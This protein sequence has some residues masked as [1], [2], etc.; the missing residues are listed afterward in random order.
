MAPSFRS[1]PTAAWLPKRSRARSKNLG[2]VTAAVPR[3]TRDT[4]ASRYF[5]MVSRL[6]MP[7]PISTFKSVFLQIAAIT[8]KLGVVP[9]LAPSRSTVWSH[10]AP[11]AW[12]SA[13]WAAGS[14]R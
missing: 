3:I 8:G 1:T 14:S 13:A 5:W 12:K 10:L 4:P 2:S 7:P 6:R 9:S 11:A